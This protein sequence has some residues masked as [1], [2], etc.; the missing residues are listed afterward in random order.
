MIAASLVPPGRFP[1]LE[2]APPPGWG[3]LAQLDEVQDL[4]LNR[5]FWTALCAPGIAHDLS[6]QGHRQRRTLRSLWEERSVTRDTLAAQAALASF[7]RPHTFQDPQAYAA[8]ASALRRHL[9]HLNHLQPDFELSLDFGLTPTRPPWRSAAA[10]HQE[11]TRWLLEGHPLCGL[12][13]GLLSDLSVARP[14]L[15]LFQV[16][17]PQTLFSSFLLSALIRRRLPATHLCLAR[18]RYENF[19]LSP[20]LQALAPILSAHFDSYAGRRLSSKTLVSLAQ[21]AAF[22]GCLPQEPEEEAPP[23]TPLGHQAF[24]P[25]PL[26]TLRLSAASCYWG[27]C[28]FCAQKHVGQAKGTLNFDP[29]MDAYH[30]GVRQ[31]YFSDEALSPED[32]DRL[33]ETLAQ[34]KLDLRWSARV[35]ID[36][37]FNAAR[38]RALRDAGCVELLVGLES[39]SERVLRLMQKSDPV[40]TRSETQSWLFRAAEAQL[41]LHLNLLLNF[42]GERLD[43][44]FETVDF[45]ADVAGELPNTTLTLNRFVLYPGTAVARHPERFGVQEIE[46][47]P[48]DLPIFL[49]YRLVSEAQR[50]ADAI[51]AHLRSLHRR[52]LVALRRDPESAAEAL[53]ANSGHSLVAKAAAWSSPLFPTRCQG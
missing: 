51:D 40:R 3:A 1:T 39:A 25:A 7:S 13:D 36:P 49:A 24:T 18:H 35:R 2:P 41:G 20:H 15:I 31:V 23:S 53:L 45:V 33:C 12:L 19:A 6:P 42:P 22:R 38:M 16:S 46:S 44:A 29:L 32:L 21:G 37:D 52:L 30:Q 17:S 9:E 4:G 10:L 28:A 34:E 11:A 48:G 43:E 47:Q 14:R 26:Q 5:R 8:A 50:E 27:R